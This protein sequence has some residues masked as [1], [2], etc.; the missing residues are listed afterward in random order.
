MGSWHKMKLGHP[1]Q[2]NPPS[3]GL[4]EHFFAQICW[5]IKL[6]IISY[7]WPSGWASYKY[8]TESWGHGW[9]FQVA[10][11]DCWVADLYNMGPNI[12]IQVDN[13]LI[14]S[15]ICHQGRVPGHGWPVSEVSR[16]DTSFI[17]SLFYLVS[18][19]NCEQVGLLGSLFLVFL[20]ILLFAA[21]VG[22]D[23]LKIR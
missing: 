13:I 10:P 8:S 4:N 19:F 6:W 21:L 3:R 17:S 11:A 5:V 9:S 1:K 18:T 2:N 14:L 15:T 22:G 7:Y 23:N 16:L 20:T 12:L